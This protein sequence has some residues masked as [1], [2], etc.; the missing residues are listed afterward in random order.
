YESANAHLEVLVPA[1]R[2]GKQALKPLLL[3]LVVE[4]RS[5][6]LVV[7]DQEQHAKQDAGPIPESSEN[8]AATGGRRANEV[9]GLRARGR[10]VRDGI[11]RTGHPGE[12]RAQG[13]GG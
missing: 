9:I 12:S 6:H 7:A 4:D 3:K 8:I 13:D 1:H 10:L 2:F 11:K 5:E